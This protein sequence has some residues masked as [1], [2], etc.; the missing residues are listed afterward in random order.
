MLFICALMVRYCFC[1]RSTNG[2]KC[3][4]DLFFINMFY[5]RVTN[6]TYSWKLNYIHPKPIRTLKKKLFL[7]QQFHSLIVSGVYILYVDFHQQT[8][9]EHVPNSVVPQLER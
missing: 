9:R 3:F 2:E 8:Q 6:L 4:L 1:K 5:C 7:M